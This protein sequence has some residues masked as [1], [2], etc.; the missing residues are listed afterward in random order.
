[1]DGGNRID[2]GNRTDAGS[3]I[4]AG[5]ATDAG[6]ADAGTDAGIDPGTDAGIDA[7]PRSCAD[8]FSGTRGYTE[9]CPGSVDGLRCVLVVVV[10]P[11]RRTCDSVC[12]EAGWSCAGAAGAASTTPRCAEA[13]D[14]LCDQNLRVQVCACEP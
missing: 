4:D 5:D 3:R 10:D 8:L 13:P 7:G 11:D 14:G 12:A 9:V 6:A 1:M 2:A